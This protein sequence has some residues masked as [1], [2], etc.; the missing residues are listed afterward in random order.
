MSGIKDP[1]RQDRVYGFVRRYLAAYGYP[2]SVRE[3]GAAVGLSSTST[4]QQHL[5]ALV[6]DGRLTRRDRRV[7]TLA[8]PQTAASC[9]HCGGSGTEPA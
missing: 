1:L 9:S 2:P 6:R 5:D 7:R 3:I 4:V 8:L